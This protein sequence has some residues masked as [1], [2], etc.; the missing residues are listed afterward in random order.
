VIDVKTGEALPGVSV[1]IKGTTKGT[2]TGVDGTYSIQASSENTLLFQAIGLVS[3]EIIVGNQSTLD[4]SMTIDTTDLEEVVITGYRD[5]DKRTF[6]GSATAVTSKSIALVPVASI[7]QILQGQSPGLSVSATSGQPGASAQ[8]RIRGTGSINGR[9]QPLYI[10]D[11][12]EIT[13]QQFGTLNPND[14]ERIDILRDASSSAIYG[15]RGTNGVIVITSKRGKAQKTQFNYNV[16]YG[17]SAAPDW[18]VKVLNT[19]QKIDLELETGIGIAP[20]LSSEEIAELRT[21][22]TDW[23]EEILN[24]S[25]RTINHEINATGGNGNTTFYVSGSIFKQEGVVKNTNLDRYTGRV[26]INHN[27]GNFRFGTNLSLG[28]SKSNYTREANTGLTSPLNAIRWSNPYEPVYVDGDFNRPLASGYRLRSNQPN[29]VA[30][31][32]LNTRSFEDVKIV[33]TTYL[34]Y[35][36]AAIKG[37]TFRTNW[38]VDYFQSND[39]VLIDPSTASGRSSRGLNGQ[40]FRQTQRSARFTGTTSLNYDTKFGDDHKLNVG[41]FQE[42]V[43][44]QFDRFDFTG[45]GLT[46]RLRNE[47]GITSN[48]PDFIPLVGGTA[49]QNSLVSFFTDVNYSFKNKYSVRANARVDG[50]S[51]FGANNRYAFFYSL[52]AGWVLSDENFMS[53]A[54]GFVNLLKLRASYGVLGNQEGIGDFASFE[55]YG[56]GA[57]YAG[58]AGVN[59]LSLP[60]PDLKWESSSQLNIGLDYGVWDNRITGSID[61]YN[62]LTTDLYLEVEL[63]RSSGFETQLQNIGEM[64]NRGFEFLIN[65]DVV[66]STD[67]TWSVGGNFSYNKNEVLKLDGDRIENIDGIDITRVGAPL[68]SFYLVPYAG[69][70]PTNGDALYTDLNGN[71]T[72]EFSLS[73]SRLL[74]TSDAPWIGGFNTSFRYKTLELSALFTWMTGKVSYNNERNNIDNPD[75]ITDNVSADLLSAWRQPGDVTEVPR[76]DNATTGVP[77]SPYFSETTRYLENSKFLRLR[78]VTLAYNL[79][80]AWS[81]AIRFRTIRVFVQGQ[82]LLTFTPWRGNDPEV[83]NATG[84]VYPTQRTFTFGLNAGF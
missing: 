28:Y 17:V 63:S 36:I 53:F 83:I 5:E 38:G 19:N 35:D 2:I 15:S 29:G 57:N 8:V 12:I 55:L 69:V 52:G 73:D 65:Y 44:R 32:L 50:S 25:A 14:F 48:N 81:N 31:L 18:R 16:Q 64:R 84:A 6:T 80:I 47:A 41:L 39:E 3:Q 56:G 30:E 26:N 59:P 71:V 23:S 67:F 61:F 72:P 77:R 33:A 7:D 9:N 79:P 58:I 46:G 34:E 66:R 51:R 10:L 20:F 4:L 75:Y 54:D 24:Q 40:L 27:A 70:N 21:V 82:N 22:E 68:N 11:G 37:L 43:Y 60:N 13:A 62:K 76:I 74:G 45:F 49:T 42:I 1:S 78:N